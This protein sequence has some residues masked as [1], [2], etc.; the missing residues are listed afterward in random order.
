MTDSSRIK[1]GMYWDRAWSIVEGCTQC[2]PGCVHCWSA[3][4]THMR[5]AQK[6]QKIG[7]RYR[8]L[9]NPEGKFTGVIRLMEETLSLPITE[10][11]PA[12]WAVWNDLFHEDVPFSFIDRAFGIMALA[13]QHTYLV[14][15]KR[16][17]RVLEWGE[18]L[19]Q[20]LRDDPWDCEREEMLIS[21]LR[22]GDESPAITR[23]SYNWLNTWNARHLGWPL[24]HVLIG[25]T[26]CNQEE[27]ERNIPVLLQL[28][29]RGLAARVYVSYEPALGPVDFTGPLYAV[30]QAGR[31]GVQALDAREMWLPRL[32]WIVAG[33]ESGRGRR[34]AEAAWFQ[35][36][37]E[38][39]DA[40]GIPFFLKQ[41]DIDGKVVKAPWLNAL[42]MPEV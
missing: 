6:N 20:L 8:G 12:T 18:H 32:D 17:D 14:L 29:A 16:I 7:R 3:E 38:Q 23:A 2:S 40:A 5:A 27:A 42:Q 21:I 4:Q 13:D 33:C 11:Q 9:T 22:G 19:Q 35:S 36:V 41:I 24:P 31:P 28:K 37:F 10:H 30:G 1:Q 26:C 25:V 34:P 15:T 39:C